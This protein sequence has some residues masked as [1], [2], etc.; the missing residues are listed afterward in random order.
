MAARGRKPKPTLE[1]VLAGE[2]KGRVNASPP[3]TARGL[4]ICPDH[5]DADPHAREAWEGI[6]PKLAAVGVLTELDGHALALYCTTYSRWR[7]A[8]EGIRTG[9]VTS[10][11]DQGSLKSNPAVSVASQCERFMA[12]IL[13]EFGLT[14]SSRSRVK[15]DAAPRDALA[16]FLSRREG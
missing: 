16:E 4:P 9:G 6:V 13:L 8:C 12:A 3:A 2:R 10:F 5:I 14:P 7:K 1:K 11:T 15:T